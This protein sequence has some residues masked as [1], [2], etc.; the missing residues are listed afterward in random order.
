VRLKVMHTNSAM[1]QIT[2]GVQGLPCLLT[3]NARQALHSSITFNRTLSEV[4][5]TVIDWAWTQTPQAPDALPEPLSVGQWQ[6]LDLS[7]DSLY[8]DDG[9]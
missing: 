1:L 2:P 4:L 8:N 3:P 7:R 9:R 5:A 6:T